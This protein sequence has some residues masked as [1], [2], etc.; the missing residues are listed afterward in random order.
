MF[1]RE[2]LFSA[3]IVLCRVILAP[4]MLPSV[5][6][7]C[8]EIVLA[9]P[10]V[11]VVG[12]CVEKE[13]ALVLGGVVDQSGAV[14]LVAGVHHAGEF[15]HCAGIFRAQDVITEVDVYAEIF[16]S[17]YLI[18]NL[19]IADRAHHLVEAVLEF[20]LGHGVVGLD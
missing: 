20:K 10:V 9:A 2:E 6:G 11:V 8:R 7:H 13:V 19:G 17:V 15:G 4:E 12:I 5:T 18:I 16:K 14:F 3:G 1:G